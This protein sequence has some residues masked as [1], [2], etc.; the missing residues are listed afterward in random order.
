MISI[1]GM[2]DMTLNTCFRHYMQHGESRTRHPALQPIGH[3]AQ[4]ASLFQGSMP[5]HLHA[6]DL[7]V[8]HFASCGCACLLQSEQLEERVTETAA[9]GV[10]LF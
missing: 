1:E 10:Q 4:H 6:A 2:A 9:R 8:T 3:C 5:V 7:Q